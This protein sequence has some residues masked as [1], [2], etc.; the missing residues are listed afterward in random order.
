MLENNQKEL[1]LLKTLGMEYPTPNSTYKRRYGIYKCFCGKE[2]KNIISSVKNNYIKS[3]GCLHTVHNLT[4][5]RLYSIW[6][7]MMQRC[8]NLKEKSH[9]D[10]GARGIL[11]CQKWHNV[12]NFI[13]DMNSTFKESLTLDRIDVNGNYELSNCRW[14]TKTIQSRNTQKLRKDNSSGYRGVSWHKRDLVWNA[15]ISVDK[16]RIHLGYFNTAL[17]GALAYDKYVIDNNLEHTR[18]FS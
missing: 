16:K 4:Q 6:N 15:K 13:N 10:Y 18:N 11:V 5:H 14:V 9:K 8:Y 17:D 3:C 12:E 7:S 1:I 2:F